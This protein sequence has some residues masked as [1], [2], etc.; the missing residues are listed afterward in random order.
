MRVLHTQRPQKTNVWAVII[1]N[2]IVGP[3]F[4]DDTL[5][6]AKYLRLLQHEL[7]PKCEERHSLSEIDAD[8]TVTL[9]KSERTTPT[10]VLGFRCRG[11][12]F[13]LKLGGYKIANKCETP[14]HII[15]DL[16][17]MWDMPDIQNLIS[18]KKH[19]PKIPRN[20]KKYC[21]ARHFWIGIV[22]PF[23]IGRNL[24]SEKYF[25]LLRYHIILSCRLLLTG[26]NNVFN[27]QLWFQQDGAP[28]HF[29]AKYKLTIFRTL[30]H[31]FFNVQCQTKYAVLTLFSDVLNTLYKNWFMC[32]CLIVSM[33]A[34]LVP[35][36]SIRVSTR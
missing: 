15:T 27:Q 35:G 10:P 8:G 4:F 6:G 32:I 22:E 19:T 7:M 11:A 20:L 12:R 23:I 3:L 9:H 21:L 24:K 5:N 26:E 30:D 16:S 29:A 14:H 34:Q 1:Q 17:A 13:S 33:A 25:D 31:Y 36:K 2:R 28:P 18:S